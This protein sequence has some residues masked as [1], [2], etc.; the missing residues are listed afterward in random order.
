MTN[1]PYVP[2]TCLSGKTDH[3]KAGGGNARFIVFKTDP[4]ERAVS[5]RETPIGVEA[6]KAG[7]SVKEAGGQGRRLKALKLK[8]DSRLDS[9]AY[10]FWYQK[11]F[12]VKE[13][14]Y[15][16]VFA[17]LKHG[18]SFAHSLQRK[19][20]T[21]LKVRRDAACRKLVLPLDSIQDTNVD[22][23]YIMGC[24]DILNEEEVDKLLKYELPHLRTYYRDTYRNMLL[25]DVILKEEKAPPAT[26]ST[27][28]ISVDG[29]Y[30]E[31]VI[32]RNP[33]KLDFN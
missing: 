4:K 31:I 27:K 23:A 15:L 1:Q 11:D 10:G 2:I 24:F 20:N 21:I 8:V 12:I 29:E 17:S 18:D 19:C 28:I 6:A 22:S 5:R 3:P 32:K 33:R 26:L 9:P 25:S 30:R 13:G 14:T 7:N 16:K